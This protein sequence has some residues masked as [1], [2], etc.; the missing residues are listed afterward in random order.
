[1]RKLSEHGSPIWYDDQVSFMPDLDSPKQAT[2]SNYLTYHH[3]FPC[4]KEQD[5]Q[6]SSVSH[7]GHFFQLPLLESPKLLQPAPATPTTAFGSELIQQTHGQNLNSMPIYSSNYSGEPGRAVD[8]QVTDWRVLDKFVASQLSQEDV[9]K[10]NDDYSINAANIFQP[11]ESDHNQLNKQEMIT[12][13]NAGSTSASSC[14]MD[15]WK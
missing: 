8:H 3:P 12:P 1:M 13:E 15:L 14:Q 9:P 10:E 7:G 2:Q 6:Y 5:L 11:S 4:K